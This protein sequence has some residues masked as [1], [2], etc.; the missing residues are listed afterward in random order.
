MSFD[1]NNLFKVLELAKE[2]I[3][4]TGPVILDTRII[5]HNSNSRMRHDINI[6]DI[7]EIGKEGKIIDLDDIM[8]AFK[9]IKTNSV[10]LI[11]FK[12]DRSY[13]FE[14]FEKIY[15]LFDKNDKL[16]SYYIQWGS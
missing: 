14:G 8:V 15:N 9:F 4:K 16:I 1:I 3:G 5:R 12:S 7:I 11:N 10:F 2:I 13:I 6:D